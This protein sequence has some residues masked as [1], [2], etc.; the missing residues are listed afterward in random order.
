MKKIKLFTLCVVTLIISYPAFADELA[1][2]NGTS[3][4]VEDYK[5]N[6]A[7]VPPNM[8]NQ[9][10]SFDEKKK[11]LN[12]IVD[13]EL[14]IQE[15]KKSGLDKDPEYID[16]VE[17]AKRDLLVKMMAQKLNKEKVTEELMRTYFNKNIKYYE[18]VH[19]SHILLKTEEEALKVKKE[20]SAGGNFSELAK[21]Y[22]TD[23]GSSSKGGD[24]GFF[25]KK[26]MVPAFSELAFKLKPNEMGG[27][28]KTQ[29]G[30]HLIK[31]LEV[32][33]QKFEDLTQENIRDIR[34]SIINDEIDRLRS[35]GKVIL[36]EEALKKIE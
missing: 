25:S 21:K 8:K 18:L 27:P 7:Q 22:S 15:A 2:V 12:I 13:R 9:F 34:T 29:F 17:L 11:F 35:K 23:P 20:L 32:K 5:K 10:S 4:S 30:Y 3:I 1:N 14:L 24:L 31:V 26:Q 33:N 36:N 19:A 16:Q 6:M 28:V